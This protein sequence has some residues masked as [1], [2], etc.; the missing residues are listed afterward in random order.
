MKKLLARKLLLV[1]STVIHPILFAVFPMV[2]LYAH[3]I[4]ETSAS[5]TLKPILLLCVGSLILWLLLSLLLKNALK[6]GLATTVFIVLFSFY[7]RFYDLLVSSS[8]PLARH[9][10][11]FPTTLLVWGYCT[12]MIS[13]LRI[14]LRLATRILNVVAI[15]LVLVNAATITLHEIGKPRLPMGSALASQ[16]VAGAELTATDLDSMP[17]IYYIILD[18]YAHPDT[19]LEYYDYDNSHFIDELVDKGFFVASNSRVIYSETWKAVSSYLNMEYLPPTQCMEFYY[20]KIA[21][22]AVAS[23]LKTIGYKYVYF[24][25]WFDT[26][27]YKVNADVYYNFYESAG[28]SAVASEFSRTLWNTT[29][30]RPFYDHLTGS[31]YA[32]QYRAAIV[33]TLETLKT[34]PDVEGP[35]FVFAH[36][37]CPHE[38]FVFGE[39]GEY[40]DPAYWFSEDKQAYLGQYEYI[41]NEIA[42]VIGELLEKSSSDPIIILQSDHGLRPWVSG[43][44]DVGDTEWQKV[45]NAYYLPNGGEDALYDSI[46]PVN[47]FRVI[48]N[49]YFGTDYGFLED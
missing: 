47:S 33:E 38:P 29:M 10:Y 44:A 43:G 45:L 23:S 28:S 2:F 21:N 4:G 1:A 24:G 22:S 11:L 26:G 6:A 16:S 46:S 3:N 8:F 48:F 19:M 37:V 31:I 30:A 27:R 18:E 13:T 32:G 15:V 49:R 39:E 34:I 9:P 35:K 12:Y 17:D 5:Q 20:Q 40:V 36:I 7:G 42:G 14:D 25:S 41:S